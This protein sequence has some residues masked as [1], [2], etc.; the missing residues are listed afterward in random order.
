VSSRQVLVLTPYLYDTAPG[1]RSSIELWERV[2][3]PAG[4]RFEYAPFED[5]PLHEVVY[6][7]GRWRDKARLLGRAYGRRF[8]TVGRAAGYDAVLVYR[9][10]ALIGPE[11]FERW[12]DRL[13]VP[14]IYQLDDPLYV[15]YRS[16]SNGYLSYLKFFGKVGRIAR[17]SAMTIVNSRQHLEYVARYTSRIRIIPILVDG[18]LYKPSDPARADCV[19]IG[20]S[21]SPPTAPN[22]GLIRSS[23]QKLRARHD[24]ELRFIGGRQYDLPGV[25]FV[26]VQW[27][28]ETEIAELRKF[29]IGLLP[30]LETEWTKRKFFMKLIQYMS[31]GIPP[32]CTPIGANTEV[33]EHG[34]NGLFAR[35]AADW[36]R[37][38][39]RLVVDR[40]LRRAIGDR[41]AETA[42]SQYTIQ[43]RAEEIVDV[44]RA[45]WG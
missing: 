19:R 39:E 40:D 12:V 8:A 18:S 32:V 24:V 35:C 7:S 5:Q 15:P 29:D 41:A 27:T 28:P 3:E 13:R 20:W 17:M 16:P 2:L 30:V 23:L 44:F 11:L 1:P 21:G 22:L 34:S 4:I 37:Q 26:D 9:E 14:I 38:L 6:E 43:A 25:R 45:V 42:H 33:V 36:D 10:A 31:L